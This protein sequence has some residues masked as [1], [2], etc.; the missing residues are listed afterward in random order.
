MAR[1]RWDRILA[2]GWI[3]YG[4]IELLRA[5]Y[6]FIH[7]RVLVRSSDLRDFIG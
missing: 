4:S 3:L 2:L 1:S 5:L 7:I 6:Y